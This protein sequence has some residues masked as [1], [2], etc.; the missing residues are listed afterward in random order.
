MA[1]DTAQSTDEQLREQ[2]LAFLREELPDGWMEAIDEGDEERFAALRKASVT[3]PLG[4][5][6]GRAGVN[7]RMPWPHF[8]PASPREIEP[9][10]LSVIG[11]KAA[12]AHRRVYDPIAGAHFTV[13][14]RGPCSNRSSS[15]ASAP[16]PRQRRRWSGRGCSGRRRRSVWVTPCCAWKPSAPLP[17]SAG[18]SNTGWKA[19][20][21]SIHRRDHASCRSGA[22]RIVSKN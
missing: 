1:L 16:C 20:S 8:S 17:S 3:S 2:T 4:R 5:S 10:S 12:V 18:F 6:S 15:A 19:T 11:V 14:T 9:E 21:P 7:V 13:A 22:R